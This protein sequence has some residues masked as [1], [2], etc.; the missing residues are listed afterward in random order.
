MSARAGS[1]LIL[2]SHRRSLGAD[3]EPLRYL[4]GD[5]LYHLAFVAWGERRMSICGRASASRC[6]LSAARLGAAAAADSGAQAAIGARAHIV[7][8]TAHAPALMAET[9]IAAIRAF[10]LEERDASAA[11]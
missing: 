2:R 8:R 6:S 10:L 1:S 4:L 11:G 3:M 9:E 7:P 5:A